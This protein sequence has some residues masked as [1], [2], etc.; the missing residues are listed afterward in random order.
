MTAAHEHNVPGRTQD[1]CDDLPRLLEVA[2]RLAA[3]SN[4][5]E[6]LE[7]ILDQ[8][9]LL[10]DA[11]R[12]SIFL[13]DPATREL[14]A[15]LATGVESLRFSVDQGIA[16]AAARD[17]RIINVPDAYADP[18]FNREVDRKTG[19]TTRNILSLP[20]VDYQGDLVGVLQVLNKRTGQFSPYDQSL[21]EM[22]GAQAGVALQRATL[23]EQVIEKERL[24]RE[25]SI[26]RE[27]QQA[28]LPKSDPKIPGF[29]LAGWNKSADQT[30]GD[31]YDFFALRDGSLAIT[32]ADATGH[33]IGPALVV[34][35]ARALF[36]A[37]AHC[38]ICD[39]AR[40]M[41]LVNG[42]LSADLPDDRFVTA[43]FGILSPSDARIQWSSGGHGPMLLYRAKDDSIQSF[44]ATAPPMGIAPELPMPA[45]ATVELAPG[46]QF[47]VLTDGFFE[48][49]DSHGE[50][51][52]M[53]RVEQWL[54]ASRSIPAHLAI[55]QLQEQ[56]FAFAGSA[57]QKD[58]LTAVLIRRC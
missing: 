1:S 23:L 4:L 20:L 11:E 27:I 58:D 26:A 53:D 45:G 31:C 52:G 44:N 9:R 14:F 38:I 28:L 13:Y 15:R 46:D 36:R 47:L 33:G 39:I 7:L 32:V 34:A 57:P 41:D 2:R 21:A 3:T 42:I 25:L 49:A 40:L 35:E 16:G 22:L 37:A 5:N 24:E 50:Q 51:F 19:F 54:R 56:V 6:L 18:R 43:F 10:L 48:F 12:A 29:E 8:A 17:R 55:Q 30:G